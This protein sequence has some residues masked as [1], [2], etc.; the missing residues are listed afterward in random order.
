MPI[1]QQQWKLYVFLMLVFCVCVCVFFLQEKV[2]QDEST[3]EDREAT[4]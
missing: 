4:E 3:M 1:F 2:K